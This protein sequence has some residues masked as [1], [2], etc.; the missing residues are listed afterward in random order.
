MCVDEIL[1]HRIYMYDETPITV[2]IEVFFDGACPWC[3]QATRILRQ[4]DTRKKIRFTDI[5]SEDFDKTSLG[6]SWGALLGQIHGRLPDGTLVKG[7]EVFRQIYTVI[8]FGRF[9]LLTRLPG[10]SHLLNL[11]YWIFATHRPRITTRCTSE[12]CLSHK[13][14]RNT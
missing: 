5:S 4:R 7:I 10:V 9:V 11:A 8:G 3:M 1:S 2:E 6:L 14:R 13:G 12:T